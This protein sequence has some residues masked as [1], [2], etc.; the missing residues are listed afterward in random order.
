MNNEKKFIKLTPFKMQV[1][2]SFPFIDE[3]F[4]AITNYELLCKVVEYLN[5]TV[6][7]VDLL[8]EKVEE[9]QKYF[10]NL[11]VQDEINNK[12]D[13]M[14]ESGQLAEII[15]D[16][17]TI[18]ELTTRITTLENNDKNTIIL[19][20]DSY[21]DGIDTTDRTYWSN[22]IGNILHKNVINMCEASSG[23]VRTG[24]RGHNF[25]DNLNIAYESTSFDNNDV[26]K[27]IVYGGYNDFF[28]I[29]SEIFENG[30]NTFLQNAKT[31]Y[32]NCN[33]IVF[34]I[35]Y[36]KIPIGGSTPLFPQTFSKI[37]RECCITNGIS[38]GDATTWLWNYDN[39]LITDNVHPNAN[40]TNIIIS[41]MIDYFTGEQNNKLTYPYDQLGQYI[42]SNNINFNYKSLSSKSISLSI[43]FKLTQSIGNPVELF[44]SVNKNLNIHNEKKYPIYTFINNTASIV[45]FVTIQT[46]GIWYLRFAST[47]NSDT[48]YY[49]NDVI[50]SLYE[51]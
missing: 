21:G 28:N 4:D 8:N 49:I 7:N 24:N 13:E 29:S 35:N 9:F 18:P 48:V 15:E 31:K 2:Q 47:P 34:G 32:P 45:G 33:I 1:L 6:D 44:R 17:A 39:V 11:D 22:R 50:W 46:N 12:L 16:Y 14:A 51:E 43:N 36:P 37:L 25:N 38:Y 30:V 3:D 23:F 10:D 42:D 19:I 27:I 5:K 26:D 40:G 20:G 41:K